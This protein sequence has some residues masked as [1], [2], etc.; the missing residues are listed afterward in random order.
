MGAGAELS[1]ERSGRPGAAGSAQ[2]SDGGPRDASTTPL[3]RARVRVGCSPRHQPN[4]RS[5]PSRTVWS[6]VAFGRRRQGVR[7]GEDGCGEGR[8]SEPSAGPG[9]DGGET[10]R[11]RGAAGAGGSGP[12]CRLCPAGPPFRGL[13]FI[14]KSD[15]SETARSSSGYARGHRGLGSL[16]SARDRRGR[17]S[18]LP[19][20]RG[21]QQGRVLDALPGEG[22]A[23]G[24][25]R[26]QVAR[27]I[28][29]CRA[30]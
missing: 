30:L 22:A 24:W 11:G 28:G 7:S 18:G 16:V 9:L 2:L 20:H 29:G 13:W 12:R 27:R 21:L 14:L 10:W 15:A 23:S 26:A 4:G 5:L 1:A 6:E 8:S 17:A 3:G 19:A 25:A